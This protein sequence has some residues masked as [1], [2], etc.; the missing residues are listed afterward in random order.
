MKDLLGITGT[1]L[2][3][4]GFAP[5][6]YALWRKTAK[7]HA[8]SWFLWGIINA[9][10]CAVQVS[11][12]AGAGAWTAGVA[13]TFNLGITVYA[14]KHGERNI[15]RGDWAVL[16]SVL[17]AL[18]LWVM[19]SNPV[20][21]VILVSVI[22]TVAFYP[23]LRKSWNRPHEEVATTFVLGMAGFAFALMALD[24]P[25][26]TNVCYP[27]KVILTNGIFVSC[28]FYRRMVL[29]RGELTAA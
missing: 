10:V 2:L 6:L 17:M 7:P 27:A 14:L 24:N 4:G 13:A 3:M 1:V 18:P 5:Y 16:V 9:I 19:T 22:D 15:T 23:T 21:S 11:Q 8:F 26:F 20:W 29:A 12:G 28:L 25:S